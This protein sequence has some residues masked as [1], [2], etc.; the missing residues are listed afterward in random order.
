MAQTIL[1]MMA[2]HPLQ[3]HVGCRRMGLN[4][5]IAGKNWQ[6][7]KGRTAFGCGSGERLVAGK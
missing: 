2:A 7:K 5:R 1:Q 4:L 3:G 6:K